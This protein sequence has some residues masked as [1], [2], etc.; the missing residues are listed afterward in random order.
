MMR[1]PGRL[2]RRAVGARL[3]GTHPPTTDAPP[4]PAAEEG[5][6]LTVTFV[7][8]T[9][10]LVDD[11]SSRLLIDPFFSRPGV[12]RCAVGKIGPDAGTIDGCLRRLGVDRLDAVVA[13]HA[14]YDHAMDAPYVAR[15][16][17]AQLVGSRSTAMIGA[18]FGLP[19]ERMTLVEPDDPL[20]VGALTVTFARSAHVA[21]V[22]FPGKISA[23]LTPPARL[24]S[25]RV[26]E[27]YSV[28]IRAGRRA[29][30]V[31]GSA[32]SVAGSLSGLPTDVV[33]LAIGALSRATGAA[34]ERYWDEVVTTVGA[35]RVLATHWDNLWRPLSLPLAPLPSV[36]DDIP[37]TM[38]FLDAHAAKHGVDLRVPTS[39]QAT[40]P[41]VGLAG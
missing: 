28:H 15:R 3:P 19:E 36:L 21:P 17:G 41:F 30:L 2:I 35:R 13:S 27:C 34:R 6:D 29:L 39:W 24:S 22:H 33:Y 9:T 16:T 1:S 37:A 12:V 20:Q 4:L 5:S 10:L 14:H 25:Y 31:Q 11:G 8:A 7:G 23:P 18:G 32:G 26:G 40:D 38:R